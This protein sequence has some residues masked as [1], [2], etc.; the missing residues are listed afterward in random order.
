ME[1]TLKD[2]G[3]WLDDRV[4]FNKLIGG[5]LGM[6]IE[7]VDGKLFVG[8]LEF[9]ISKV[10]E[11]HRGDI[12]EALQA[13]MDK[14]YEKLKEVSTDKIVAILKTPLGDKKEGIIIGGLIGIVFGL[15]DEE[16]ALMSSVGGG[17]SG[18]DPTDDDGNG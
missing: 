16:V 13:V 3:K 11:K 1:K 9:G 6:A 8:A 17:G 18:D 12:L 15:I 5:F 7:A 4:E 2:F 10:D 14:D